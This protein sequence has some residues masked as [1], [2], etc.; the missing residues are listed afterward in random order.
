MASKQFQIQ[1]PRGW[2]YESTLDRAVS[3]AQSEVNDLVVFGYPRVLCWAAVFCCGSAPAIAAIITSDGDR[4]FKHLS[5]GVYYDSTRNR[6]QLPRF[7]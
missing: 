3:K 6:N 5:A 7:I 2:F 1:T 4:L